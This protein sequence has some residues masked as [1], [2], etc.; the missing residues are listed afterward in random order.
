MTTS[1]QYRSTWTHETKKIAHRKDTQMNRNEMPQADCTPGTPKQTQWGTIASSKNHTMNG[2]SSVKTANQ[3]SAETK[4]LYLLRDCG[5][6][7][8]QQLD[9]IGKM[10]GGDCWT[11]FEVKGKE[12]F[13]PGANFPHYGAGLDKSQLYLRTRLLGEL[14]LRTYFINF[15]KGSDE[16]YGAYLDDLETKGEFYD[17]PK[18]GIRIY[19]IDNFSKGFEAI[20]K[21][22][23]GTV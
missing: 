9:W 19:P 6:T 18:N 2:D 4:A 17:T 11:S 15:V 22:L 10:N 13:T 1:R 5:F 7:T 14:G 12:L 3:E 20:R 23:N 8:I 21:D 16:V